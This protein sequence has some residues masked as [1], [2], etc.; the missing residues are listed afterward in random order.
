[1]RRKTQ[2]AVII[3]A[4]IFCTSLFGIYAIH[5]VEKDLYSAMAILLSATLALIGAFMSVLFT[6]KTARE[7]NALSFQKALQEDKDY[8]EQVRT[9]MQAAKSGRDLRILVKTENNMDQDAK[10]IRYVLNTWERAAN[11]IRHGIYDEQFLYEAHKSMAIYFGMYF[12]EFIAEAQ[13]LQPTYYENFS[14]LVL[15]WTIRRDSF[16]EKKRRKEIKRI[17]KLLDKAAPNR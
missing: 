8:L 2:L 15:K 3:W 12:R 7:S 10:A 6:R 5:K 1:M 9:A 16:T 14:W 13:K 17:F 11:A 4:I